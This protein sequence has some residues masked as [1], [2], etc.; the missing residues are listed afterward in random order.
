MLGASLLTA[1]MGVTGLGG[2][3]LAG[4]L[5]VRVRSASGAQPL[6]AFLALVGLWAAGLLFP[7]AV[8]EKLMA[9]SPLGASVFVH[10]AARLTWRCFC[11]VRWSYAAGVA[12]TAAA[13][14]NPAGTYVPWAGVTLFRYEGAGLL[15]AGATVALATFGHWLLAD[16]WRRAAGRQ[17]RQI[18]IVMAASVFGLG[19]VTGLAFPL[20]GLDAYPWPLLLLPLYLAIL[21][22][23]VLRYELMAANQWARR[24]LTWGLLMA[25]ATALTAVLTSLAANRAPWI[26][27]ALGM[28]AVLTLWG[29]LRRTVD[30]LVFPGGDVDAAELAAW[31]DALAGANDKGEVTRMADAFLRAKLRVDLAD[32]NEAPPGPRRVI[33]V[34][35][36]LRED[37]LKDLKRRR[38]FAE[39][40]RLAELGAL[41]ATVAHDLRNPMNIVA[42]AVADAEPAVRQEVKAQ[43][44]RMDALVR[45]LLDYAKP[46]SITPVPVDVAA[47]VAAAAR[48]MDVAVEVPQGMSMQADPLRLG[49]ALGNLL[50]NAHSAA[51]RVL[52]AAEAHAAAVLIHV[53]DDGP[54]IPDDLRASLFHPFVSR[55]SGGTGL[56]LAIVA[57][58]MAAHGGSATLGERPGWATCFTLRFPR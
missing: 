48:S 15:A 8:G 5:L 57:K 46:W 24:A 14:A 19:S 32:W 4:F 47:A 11:L 28:A 58:V 9:L 20:L 44:A 45:D 40:Q 16:A 52:V 7:G 27:S 35:A 30:R 12:A 37:A 39:R 38:A 54:G 18:A 29:P 33:E 6:A 22:Y 26:A 23:G 42:M 50:A 25:L 3:G 53:C 31:R 56:G 10:F 49:Q 17:R 41:A 34:M 2:L 55:Q 21:A 36:G 51:S 43:L 1:A 13:L